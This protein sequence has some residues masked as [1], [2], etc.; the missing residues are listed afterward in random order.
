MRRMILLLMALLITGCAAPRTTDFTVSK[1]TF[2]TPLVG[3]GACANPYLYAYPNSPDEISST[4]MAD[5]E[6]KVKALHPQFVR[7]FFLQSW[8]DKDTD[9]VIAKNHPG[10]RESFIRTVRPAQES[11]R[12][13]SS[14]SGTTRRSTKILKR[15]PDDL[16]RA[17]R[18]CAVDT[19]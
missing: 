16:H 11:G 12:K 4:A 10:M 19:V 5:L 9:P 6:K 1:R 15:S 18:R 2:E 14:S 17:S 3:F 7:V 8:W 13:C